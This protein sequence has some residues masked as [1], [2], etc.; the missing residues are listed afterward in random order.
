M[1]LFVPG[2][3]PQLF[4]KAGA[5]G[6]D[7][8]ILDLEDAVAPHDKE[9][10]RANVAN[11]GFKDIYVC[12]R[13]NAVDTCWFEDDLRMVADGRFQSVMLPKCESADEAAHIRDRVGSG[14]VIIALIES[15][16]GVA[17]LD[18]ILREDSPVDQLAFGSIDYALDLGRNHEWEALLFARSQ[19]VL[20]SRAAGITAALDGVTQSIS[21]SK[22]VSADA[23]RARDLGF[24][25]KL[26]I[27]PAQIAPARS[28]FAPD[29]NMVSWARSIV[30]ACVD[31]S[32]LQVD[33]VMI[34]RPVLL[35]AQQ[36]LA[37]NAE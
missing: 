5:A 17:K 13:I 14:V 18:S 2:N 25:G 19:I 35:R 33:G 34:D 28:G 7:S 30:A 12:T 29:E 24:A 36:I 32:A 9:N 1:P 15:A 3:R 23:R 10:A 4:G 31:D 16:R 20:L 22:I 27:H 6:T 11:H 8:I 21:D 26:L 37:S